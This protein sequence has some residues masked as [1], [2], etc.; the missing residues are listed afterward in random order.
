MAPIRMI[1]RKQRL[2]D[3]LTSEEGNAAWQGVGRWSGAGWLCACT[4]VAHA[5]AEAHNCGPDVFGCTT[6]NTLEC[7]SH[8]DP[9]GHCY[10]ECDNGILR[11]HHI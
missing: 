8:G 4:D 10:S 1:G 6:F 2:F 11:C 5:W 3:L 7:L 9:D